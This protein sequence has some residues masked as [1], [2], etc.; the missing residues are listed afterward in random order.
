MYN[1]YISEL[2]YKKI[3]AT[4]Y[5]TTEST[6]GTKKKN[7][8]NFKK[9]RKTNDE[10]VAWI[11][12][13]GTNI[14]YPILQSMED[15]SYYL[16]RD[17]YGKYKYAGS[18]FIEYCNSPDFMD[19]VTLVYGHNMA[20]G[21]MFADIHKFKDEKF[22]NKHDEFYVYTDDSILTYQVVSTYVYDDRHIMNSF[23]FN[24]DDI[25]K[26]YLDYIQNP[27]SIVVSLQ[28]KL[29]HKLTIDDKIITLSTCLNQGSGR[30]LLQGV[31]INNEFTG[32]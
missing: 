5:E 19:R 22:L 15:D 8:I 24:E 1:D 25:F 32:E 13:P 11:K 21:S 3:S 18:L 6:I 20:N 7:P 29:D 31:M 16:H 26:D 14:D 28:K 30:L 27:R 23:N 10:I 9:L 17:I 2:E 4:A 12:V